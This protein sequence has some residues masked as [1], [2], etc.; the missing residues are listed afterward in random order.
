MNPA[1]TTI[2]PA[3]AARCRAFARGAGLV[4]AM[5]G[6]LVLVG[7]ALDLGWLKSV[8]PGGTTMKPNTAVGFMLSG[9][10]LGLLGEVQDRRLAIAR[11]CAA[12]AATLGWLTLAEYFLGLN[13]GF[14]D[15][16]FHAGVHT[17]SDLHP[18]RMAP[19]TAL[20]FSLL[21]ATLL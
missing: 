21:G 11:L 18:G 17:S 5:A 10:A 19:A 9:A 7:W 3:T 16:L 20:G 8:F 6:G 4:A 1:A 14:D 13:L 15:L 12:L 2:D